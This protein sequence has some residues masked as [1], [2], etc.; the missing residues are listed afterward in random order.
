MAKLNTQK[1]YAAFVL[2]VKQNILQSR[3]QAARLANTEM[4]WL[5]YNIGKMLSEKIAANNWGAKIIDSLSADLQ[6][7]LPGLHGFST[8]NLKRMRAFFESYP[9]IG[10]TVSSQLPNNKKS[11]GTGKK[12]AGSGTVKPD[13]VIGST[14]SNQLQKNEMLKMF[15]SISFSHHSL[16]ATKLKTQEHRLFYI[17]QAAQHQWSYRILEYHIETALHKKRKALLNNFAHTLPVKMKDT[18]IEAFKDEYL[19]DFINISEDDDERVLEKS[20][21]DNI[22]EFI[23]RIGKGFSFIGNQHRLEVGGDEYFTDLLFYNRHL[24]CLVAFELKRGKFKP[25]HAGKLNF[26]LNALDGQFKLPHENPSI[27]IIL[28]KEKN[29]AVVEY[30]F[31]SISNA[32]G[33]A[34]YRLSTSVPQ[35]LKGILP[36]PEELKKL[37]G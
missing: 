26:Y 33:V 22:R 5:Y 21:V 15:F 32:M 23:M 20:I 8:P 18:A 25:E 6:K 4:L 1:E 12:T 19:L 30:T 13:A 34:T 2:Q 14:L 16:I 27:G 24:Q 36:E 10:S 9:A 35:K 7:A 11:L 3:Y 29:N 31:K 17:Q 37:L 28:C